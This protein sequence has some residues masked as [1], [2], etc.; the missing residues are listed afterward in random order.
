[1]VFYVAKRASKFNEGN[2]KKKR[3]EVIQIVNR[4]EVPERDSMNL[5][6]FYR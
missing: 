3:R 1:M 4:G 5:P 2:T 6:L